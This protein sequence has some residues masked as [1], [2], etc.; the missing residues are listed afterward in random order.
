[1]QTSSQSQIIHQAEIAYSP[2]G[3]AFEKQTKTNEDQGKKQVEALKVSKSNVQQ[4]TTKDVTLEDQLNEEAN[5]EIERIKKKR[6]PGKQ[7]KFNLQSKWIYIIS[8]NL[9]Q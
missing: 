2:L 3:K 8:S 4:L 5:N 7:R 1:M 6:K 9:K